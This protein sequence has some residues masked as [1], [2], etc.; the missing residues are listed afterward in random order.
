MVKEQVLML[1]VAKIIYYGQ[2]DQ[3]Q[4]NSDLVLSK[5]SNKGSTGF[6]FANLNFLVPWHWPG[7]SM[8][9]PTQPTSRRLAYVA[10]L[11]YAV[12]RY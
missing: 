1:A 7:W 3:S 9:Y 10:P 12:T 8:Y 11:L 5:C 6:S 2:K 4:S